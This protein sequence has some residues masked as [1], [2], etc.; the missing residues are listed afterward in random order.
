MA[1]IVVTEG[2]T[3]DGV[4]PGPGRPDEGTRDAFDRGGW[5]VVIV[6]GEVR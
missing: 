4:M 3:L 2:V 1:R 6:R 5:G